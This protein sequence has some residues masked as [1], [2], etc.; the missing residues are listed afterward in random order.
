MNTFITRAMGSRA[1]FTM[2]ALGAACL[3]AMGSASA[4]TVDSDA[5]S[6]VVHYSSATLATQAGV[7]TLYQRLVQASRQVCPDSSIRD[8]GADARVRQCRDQAI[9]RA[10]REINNPQLAALYATSQRNG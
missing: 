10:I 4:A 5:P 8:L 6:L 7:H 9:A 2:L 1:K 3:A